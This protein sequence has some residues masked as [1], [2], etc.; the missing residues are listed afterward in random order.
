MVGKL[1]VTHR[2][3]WRRVELRTLREQGPDLK[4]TICHT[5]GL[6]LYSA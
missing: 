4:S 2:M 5:K 6:L 3:G 1:Q